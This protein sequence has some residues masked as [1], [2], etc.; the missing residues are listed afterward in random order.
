MQEFVRMRIEH[1]DISGAAARFKPGQVGVWI[2]KLFQYFLWVS[3]S[4]S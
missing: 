4:F 1:P 3:P 2:Q